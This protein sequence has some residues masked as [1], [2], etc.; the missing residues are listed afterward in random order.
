MMVYLKAST[1]SPG[2]MTAKTSLLSWPKGNIEYAPQNG[3]NQGR[4]SGEDHISIVSLNLS[5][6]FAFMTPLTPS[7]IRY[8]HSAATPI[9]SAAAKASARVGRRVSSEVSA[10]STSPCSVIVF[11]NAGITFCNRTKKIS[12]NPYRSRENITGQ[13]KVQSEVR[14]GIRE[15]LID[16]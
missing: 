4:G 13:G 10:T 15:D 8:A 11:T 16:I 3:R 9:E 7:G 5:T 6:P 1:R 12:S 2:I 14:E